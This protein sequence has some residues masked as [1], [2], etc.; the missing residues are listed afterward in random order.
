MNTTNEQILSEL[1]GLLE[2][3]GIAGSS[4]IVPEAELKNL[5]IDSVEIA[6]IFAHFEQKYDA[7]FENQEILGGQ[8]KTVSD[9]VQTIE[10]KIKIPA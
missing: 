1:K 2:D 4:Q 10:K 3:R 9:I 7:M 8:Y 5:A 6:L